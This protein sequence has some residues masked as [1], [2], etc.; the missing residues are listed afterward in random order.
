MLRITV[1]GTVIVTT[2]DITTTIAQRS[3]ERAGVEEV[4]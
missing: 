2:T 3:S 1:P 4:R